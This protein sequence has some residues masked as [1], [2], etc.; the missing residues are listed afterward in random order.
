MYICQ[1]LVCVEAVLSQRCADEVL[2][3]ALE[4]LA[5]LGKIF[6][7]PDSQVIKED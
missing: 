6:V 4:F 5:S 2:L 1:A 7:P 3:A